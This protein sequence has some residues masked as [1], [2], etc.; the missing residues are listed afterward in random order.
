[1]FASSETA[2]DAGDERARLAL[3]LFVVRSAAGI[4]AAAASLPRL[5]AVVFTGGIGEN[6]GGVRAAIVDR[7]A[8]LGVRAISADESGEDRVI[9][10]D[11]GG[12]TEASRRPSVLR[13]EAREDLVIAREVTHLARDGAMSA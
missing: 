5:D 13:I 6:A 7:L 11:A 9:E 4:A 1:M 2:A 8:V 12:G 3:E 10:D